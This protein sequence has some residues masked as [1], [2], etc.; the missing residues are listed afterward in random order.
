[1]K[2]NDCCG[3]LDS[4]C[5]SP[6]LVSL[7]YGY[8]IPWLL[9]WQPGHKGPTPHC[10]RVY[11]VRC[12]VFLP[13]MCVAH[14]MSDVLA[15]NG[16]S[17]WAEPT[18]LVLEPW[19]VFACMGHVCNWC[20]GLHGRNSHIYSTHCLNYL[21]DFRLVY[22][23]WEMGSLGQNNDTYYIYYFLWSDWL[24]TI[25]ILCILTLKCYTLNYY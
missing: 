7:C 11:T 25:C 15:H 1:M 18:V 20:Q 5:P 2:M 8:A 10:Y 13:M 4:S 6:A 12:L 19:H 22:S 9:L 21:T 24:L 16:V 14:G 23:N 17:P 3:Q